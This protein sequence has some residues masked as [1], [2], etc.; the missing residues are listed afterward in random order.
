MLFRSQGGQEGGG[1]NQGGQGVPGGGQ[2]GGAPQQGIKTLSREDFAQKISA[3]PITRNGKIVSIETKPNAKLALAMHSGDVEGM[4]N[5]LL[6]SENPFIR[7][8]AK[9][10]RRIPANIN[11]HVNAD[12]LNDVLGEDGARAGGAY[13]HGIRSLIMHPN[14]AA[15]EAAVTH[16]LMHGAVS[17]ILDNPEAHQQAR[18]EEHT[19]ELQSH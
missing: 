13:I 1:P 8:V 11:I 9:H 18:S 15:D 16:E 6:K 14:H 2:K 4:F 5:A 12:L 3:V 10:A 19:S 17:H 7:H